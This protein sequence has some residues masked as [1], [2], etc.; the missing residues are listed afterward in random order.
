MWVIR[1]MAENLYD[2]HLSRCNSELS[3]S[4]RVPARP[5]GSAESLLSVGRITSRASFSFSTSTHLIHLH[6]KY[7]ERNHEYASDGSRRRAVFVVNGC[8]YKWLAE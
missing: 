1:E 8:R 6:V 4:A 5:G 2:T 7:G 3:L